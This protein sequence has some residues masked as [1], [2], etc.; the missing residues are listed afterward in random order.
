MISF[1]YHALHFRLLPFTKNRQLSFAPEHH[2]ILLLLRE[3]LVFGVLLE[4]KARAEDWFGHGL[5][6]NNDFSFLLVFD[7]PWLS[8][9]KDFE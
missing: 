3:F 7:L 2:A 1:A 6:N 5:D 9:L 4:R 8:A